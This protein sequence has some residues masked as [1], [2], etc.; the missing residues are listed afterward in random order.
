MAPKSFFQDKIKWNKVNGIKGHSLDRG[1]TKTQSVW[2]V[3]FLYTS[4]A[5]I[6]V[7]LFIAMV[8]LQVVHG[9]EN[10]MR[11]EDNSIEEHVIQ[12][13]RG[14]IFDRNGKK[15]AINVPSF[16]LILDPREV[17]EDE[18]S[19]VW[20]LL[21]DVVDLSSEDLE[22]KYDETLEAEP[23]ARR[24]LLAQDITRDQVLEVRSLADELPGVW[25]D[26]SSKRNYVGGNEFSQILG[27]TGEADQELIESTEGVDMGDIV[28]REGVESFYD[29]RFRGEKGR[30]IV[31]IDA[32]QNV[33]AEYF[34]STDEPV[35][36]D[37]L[38]L[39]VD[40]DAQ[41][42]L[43][44]ILEKG[45]EDY[46]AKGAAAVI[47]NVHTGEIIASASFPTYDNNLFIGGISSKDYQELTA[48]E[49]LPMF[50]RVIAAQEPPGSMYKTLV[51]SAA[52]QEG[53]ITRNTVIQSTGYLYWENGQPYCREFGGNVY[54]AL[55]L[56]KGYAKSSNNYFCTVMLRLGIDNFV[57]YAE[58]F[59]FGGQTGIDLPGEMPGM[60]PSPENKRVL[61]ETNPYLDAI[62][63]PGDTANSGIGQGIV[64]VTPIQMANWA[65]TIAN[66]GKV[67]TPRFAYKWEHEDGEQEM[68]E[69]EV[70]RE[71]KVSS[72]NLSIVAEGMRASSYGTYSVIVPFRNSKVPIAG[73]TGTAEFGVKDPIKGYYTTTHAWVMGFFP[74]DDPKYS[75][76]VFLE[77]GGA[78]NNSAQLARYFVDWFADHGM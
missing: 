20:E 68:V 26:Y 72:E 44:E 48:D 27:Y 70:Q 36:G 13:D 76:V 65:A 49:R 41:R 22:K 47:E 42:K 57:P 29:E 25:I 21:S 53:A 45:V 39:S 51:G 58:Y 5:I 16:D 7:T 1:S 52:L 30:R 59:N 31:E 55:D 35:A 50:N 23:L 43:Y 46:E 40:Y 69:T 8:N 67:L 2:R 28:G 10:R 73:K 6:F 18:L 71:G 63:Y 37:S 38:Y 12:P 19:D 4:V 33:V 66:G 62:W 34:N 32:A 17:E 9:L 54:G 74:Y 15:L 14:V 61:S 64:T 77:A 24:V 75:F 78:S 3:I 11:S 56:I 60:V